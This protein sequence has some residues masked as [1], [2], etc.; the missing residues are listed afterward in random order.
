MVT[1]RQKSVKQGDRDER[2]NKEKQG[3]TE[4]CWSCDGNRM[5]L[6]QGSKGGWVEWDR[7]CQRSISDPVSNTSTLSHNF[8]I[9]LGGIS[10]SPN[11]LLMCSQRGSIGLRSGDC[12]GHC[13]RVNPWC[14]NY[15]WAFCRCVWDH[16]LADIW[17]PEEIAVMGKAFLKFIIQ[18]LDEKVP[19][20]PTIHPA[21]IPRPISKHAAPY[22]HR[23]TFKLHCTLN[24]SIT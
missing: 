10:Y 14:L 12:A 1:W 15:S 11:L 20:H 18:N 3:W 5:D 7:L 4:G 9:P 2:W 16:Y 6:E 13:R 22:H 21:C 8:N 19:I 24:Q 23:S 17:Y